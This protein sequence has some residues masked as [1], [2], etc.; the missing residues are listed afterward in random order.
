MTSTSNFPCG[1]CHKNIS[2]NSKAI[3]CSNCNLWIHIKCNDISNSE[4][5]IL[6]NEPDDVPWFCLKCTKIMFP[7]G[8]LED[9]ELSNLNNSDFPSFVD[10]AVS[11]EITSGLTNLPNLEDYD[12]DEHLPSNVNSGYHTMQ[13]LSSIDVSEK[14]LSIFHVNIR[15]LSLHLDE[16]LSILTS[17]KINFDVIGVSETWNSLENPIKTNVE[18]P[19]YCYFPY[20]SHSQ[21]GGVALYVKSGLNPILRPDL[22]KDS[23]DFEC[24][25]VEIENSNGKNYLFCCAYRHPSSSFD[26]FSEYLQE[27]LSNQAVFNKQVFILGDFNINL[28]NYNSST[29]ITNYVNFF[30]SKH[31]LPY[32]IHP[33][34]IS[35]HSSTLIDNIFS[36]I[37]ENE[38]QSGNILTQI[39]DHFPQFLIVKHAGITYKN[40][41]YFQHDFSKLNQDSLMN[42]FEKVD[43]S[44]INEDR[45][46]VN[47]KFN[48][49]LCNLDELVKFHAPLKKLSKGDI[50]LRNKPWI[51]RR[52]KKMMRI[53]DRLFKKLR[54]KNDQSLVDIYKKFRNRVAISLKESKADYYYNYFQKNSNNM[55]QLWSG[56]KSVID[57]RKS[58]SINVI[59]KLKDS[60][61]N[62][63]SDPAVIANIFNK[64]FVN[65]SHDITKNIPRSNNS[66]INF[67]GQRIG[68][69]FFITPSVSSD[70]H[71]I[72][73]LLDS[74]K[75]LG[76]N[77]IPIKIL[78]SLSSVVSSPLSQI[79]NE[80]FQTGIFPDKMKVAKVIP[81]FKKG[82]PLTA[83]NYR[84]ISLLS[85]FS[86]VTEKIMYKRLYSFLEN[87]EVLYNLQFGFRGSYS[88]NHALVSLTEAIKNS[89]DN[90]K[91]GCGIF[92]D[93]QKAFDTVNHDILLKKLE[94][95][96][97][98]GTA[99]D[100]FKSYL[101]NR[102]QYVSVNGYSS[103]YLSVT[104]GVPQG[105]VL[106]PLLFLIYINDLP[107]ASSKLSFYLFADDTN[108]YYEAENLNQLQS[109]VNKEL[110]KVRKWLNVNRLSLNISKTN[111]IIFNSP[112][113]SS[114]ETVNL[115]IGN[116]PI[117]R[118]SY[119]KFLGVLLDENLSWKYHLTEL[120]KKLARTCGMFFKIRHFLPIHVLVCLY[121]S[122]FSPFLQYG[123]L[124]WGLTYETH[125]NPVF[126]LQKR[127]IRAISFAHFTAPS[128]P[129]FSDLKV[130]K[131][132]DLF[133]LKLLGFVYDC[134]NKIAPPHFHSF[135]ELVESVHQYSTRQASKND[136]FLTQKNTL[137]YGLRSVRYHGAK[138]WNEIPMEIK[139]A[140]TAT[141]FRQNLKFFLFESN[142]KL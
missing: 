14:D 31:F 126:L 92:I 127:V 76:P 55:K 69:S 59:N 109:V 49:F 120:S 116:L 36:N 13:D 10:T 140:R 119:V 3:L 90:R 124:V 44:Y 87:H 85:V 18:I 88:I 122:L 7:F 82:C 53:R 107:L 5:K 96:G 113:H 35:G 43:L 48:R 137:Q 81:L 63:T 6:Q 41:S 67:M 38:T 62:I 99:L 141:S 27:V 46:D 75:S 50:K 26:S 125:I 102:K 84:P 83:S 71:D 39:T 58:N 121:N 1:I 37:T 80:S 19:G 132:H 30:F 136:I 133:Q 4:Y 104:C 105:S 21:N 17:L 72:I 2:A 57:I 101:T 135:F 23:T 97:I 28:L 91:Y 138:C 34:R 115:K 64:F 60:S 24:V 73:S 139:K 131:L 78:K 52:I 142:Y 79:I 25:W 130:L 20:Q 42:D 134:I 86:K 70:I 68:N 40:L 32:I 110:E 45:L 15:S 108:I 61:G 95:Y 77:S 100:W 123:I 66:P 9:Y 74:G 128:T 129:L 103:S 11:F 94:R 29:P 22:C 12:I 51:N 47:E 8:S 16:L 117:K 112:Q 106:G 98:R 114:S 56:I 54:K 65:V 33:S 93:L 89:L 118:T 111:F